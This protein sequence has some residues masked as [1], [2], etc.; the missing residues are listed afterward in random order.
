MSTDRF[1]RD[2][3]VAE[4]IEPAGRDDFGEPHLAGGARRAC[5]TRSG[6]R[7]GCTSSAS[8]IAAGDV[9]GYLGN[10]LGINAW[11]AR[12]PGGRPRAAS[13]SRS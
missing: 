3:L 8:T 12:P 13:T 7:P 1:D 10:R 9:G 11:R 6:T 4:A 2:R 5:S